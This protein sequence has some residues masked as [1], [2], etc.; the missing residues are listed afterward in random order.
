MKTNINKINET[1]IEITFTGN[2]SDL[3]PTIDKL[4]NSYRK[5]IKVPGFR[6]GHV[7]N[8][9]IDQTIGSKARIVGEA[10][11]SY[12]NEQLPKVF[13]EN[14]IKPLGDPKV[15]DLKP[16]QKEGDIFSF[17]VELEVQPDIV[18]IDLDSLE[19]PVD[20]IEITQKQIDDE[21]E[22]IAKNNSI[23]IPI[24]KE[25]QKGDLLQIG[26]KITENDKE[27]TKIDE[28]NYTVGEKGGLETM[29]LG[30]DDALIGHYAGEKVSFDTKFGE[31]KRAVKV[32]VDIISN[33][34]KETP[35]IDDELADI[36]F[37]LENLDQ[38]K[39]RIKENLESVAKNKQKQ[40]L[41]TIVIDKLVEKINVPIPNNTVN[42]VIEGYKEKN[43]DATAKD[44]D[45]YRENVEKT[46][47]KD[48]I[49]SAYADSL[50]IKMDD[51]E[52]YQYISQMARMYGVDTNGMIKTIIKDPNMYSSVVNEILTAKTIDKI[53]DGVKL[54]SK[55]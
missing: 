24:E 28:R 23:L 12:I 3:A 17:N 16:P 19:I 48:I 34:K 50:K 10:I 42:K 41:A 49:I 53:I 55:K 47:V 2:Y 18:L 37:G 4:Y 13:S 35:K 52:I 51:N 39:E 36:A 20:S 27:L 21:L 9:I 26:Y 25:V 5:E 7:P 29:L 33:N 14:K 31:K 8:A 40:E 1:S 43:K 15:S 32:E 6:K 44:I 54:V 22:E 38:M 11:N 30:L 45:E 46:L